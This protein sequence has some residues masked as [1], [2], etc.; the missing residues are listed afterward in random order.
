MELFTIVKNSYEPIGK[1]FGKT[2]SEIDQDVEIIKKWLSAQPHLP[3][4]MG[5]YYLFDLQQINLILQKVLK[6]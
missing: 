6:Y 2:V 3:E 5:N 4:T 1:V